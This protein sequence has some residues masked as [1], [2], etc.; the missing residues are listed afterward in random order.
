MTEF[1]IFIN[2]FHQAV[3]GIEWSHDGDQLASGGNDNV[4]NIWNKGGETPLH[5]FT[6]HQS[7]VKVC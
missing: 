6:E 5:T 2:N 3:C 1:K 7:A 4:V